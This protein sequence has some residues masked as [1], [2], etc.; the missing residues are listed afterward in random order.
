MDSKNMLFA[1]R[2]IYRKKHI[3]IDYDAKTKIQADFTNYLDG[4]LIDSVTW[5]VQDSNADVQISDESFTAAGIAT[6]YIAATDYTSQRIH[7]KVSITS[8]ASVPEICSRSFVVH[9]VRTV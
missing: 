8:D 7:V 6:A 3:Y 4:D 5:A 9:R 2:G 1:F